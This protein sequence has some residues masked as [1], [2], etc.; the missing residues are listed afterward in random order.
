MFQHAT[1]LRFACFLLALPLAACSPERARLDSAARGL[2]ELHAS[3]A[4]PEAAF[5]Q[6]A[7]H[8]FTRDEVAGYYAKIPKD[9][10]TVRQTWKRLMD[11]PKTLYFEIGGN[12]LYLFLDDAGRVVGYDL[13]SQ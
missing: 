9:D 6:S 10:S 2:A 1:R 3:R 8:V 12:Q 11:Y 7:G 4:Q 13:T 5:G